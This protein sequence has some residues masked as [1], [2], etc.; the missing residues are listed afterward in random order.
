MTNNDI[1]RRIRYA[2]DLHDTKIIE[3]CRLGGHDLEKIS[4]TN[5]LKKEEEEGYTACSDQVIT[6]FLDGLII[7]RRGYKTDQ[8]GQPVQAAVTL[9]ITN[10]II[11]KNYVSLWNSRKRI[12]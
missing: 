10:N 4:V 1:I 6:S 9:P 3:L 2:L 11:L 8:P 12:C 7:D 5:I